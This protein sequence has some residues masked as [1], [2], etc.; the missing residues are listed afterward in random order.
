[1]EQFPSLQGN[2]GG[3]G[4]PSPTDSQQ[5]PHSLGWIPTA[6]PKGGV[7][8]STLGLGP[9]ND[10]PDNTVGVPWRIHCS[11]QHP[12]S[13]CLFRNRAQEAALPSL[14]DPL[15][16][17]SAGCSGRCNDPVMSSPLQ[18]P[19]GPL[20]PAGL[21]SSPLEWGRARPC[22]GAQGVN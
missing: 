7:T 1:M 17:R 3:H 14:P 6:S 16:H 19:R 10:G 11:L 15:A 2:K 21:P 8:P 13:V 5:G 12:N 9:G 4:A 20:S 22:R 18:E